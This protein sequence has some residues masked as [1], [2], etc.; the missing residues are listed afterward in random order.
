MKDK[1]FVNDKKIV[2]VP[3]QVESDTVIK[4][5]TYKPFDWSGFLDIINDMAF[6]LRQTHIF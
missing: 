4:Y 3:L 2:F 6:K 5:F 1:F